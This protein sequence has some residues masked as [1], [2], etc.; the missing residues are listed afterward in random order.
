MDTGAGL[1]ANLNRKFLKK[2]SKGKPVTLPNI[3]HPKKFLIN[4]YTIQVASYMALT[5]Q[6]AV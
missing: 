2:P 1:P 4:G 3:V 5:D 6:Q